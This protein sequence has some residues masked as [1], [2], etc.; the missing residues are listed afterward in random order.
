M[1]QAPHSTIAVVC[2]NAVRNGGLL[3]IAMVLSC[4][5]KKEPPLGKEQALG[6]FYLNTAGSWTEGEFRVSGAATNSSLGFAI[7][8]LAQEN[9]GLYVA[10]W[11]HVINELASGQLR[12]KLQLFLKDSS[13]DFY[14]AEFPLG[15]AGVGAEYGTDRKGANYVYS[16]DS[17]RAYPLF[18]FSGIQPVGFYS[19][20]D[21][22]GDAVVTRRFR[23]DSPAL[24]H[25]KLIP[26]LDYRVKL[27]VLEPIPLTNRCLLCL[28]TVEHQPAP[29]RVNP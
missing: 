5:V 27:T 1:N 8:G 23:S 18:F 12:L 16:G 29:P 6:T 28:Y 26:N 13:N 10:Q 19:D 22:M 2:K 21:L 20:L 11:K 25:G 4:G 24:E 14:C 17:K 3:A 9:P 7:Q 15:L